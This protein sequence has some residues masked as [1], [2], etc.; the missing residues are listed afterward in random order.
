MKTI[1][2]MVMAPIHGIKM[3][4]S[5]GWCFKTLIYFRTY[6][7]T[8]SLF[9]FPFCHGIVHMKVLALGISR[10]MRNKFIFF[11]NYPV[12]DIL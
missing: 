2:S 9:L 1:K 12:S 11:I 7:H 10:E 5:T 6:E 3:R 8:V 4:N